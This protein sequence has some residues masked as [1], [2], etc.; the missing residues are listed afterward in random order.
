MLYLNEAYKCWG[1]GGGGG[2]GLHQ[3]QLCDLFIYQ[4]WIFVTWD[5]PKS[6]FKIFTP[7]PLPIHCYRLYATAYTALHHGWNNA[8]KIS[9]S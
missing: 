2:Q 5:L 7:F 6:T 1:G 4:R 8:K 3:Y 9:R